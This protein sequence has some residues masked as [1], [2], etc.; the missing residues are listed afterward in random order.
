MAYRIN[1]FIPVVLPALC[2][3]RK[4]TLWTGVRH[5]YVDTVFG[6]IDESC[7]FWHL[8]MSLS[9]TVAHASMFVACWSVFSRKITCSG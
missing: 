2:T 3:L 6:N 8:R 7:A 4:A 1:I 5:P 9:V